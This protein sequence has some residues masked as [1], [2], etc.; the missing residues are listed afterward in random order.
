MTVTAVYHKANH[1]TS[2]HPPN[3]IEAITHCL[4][5]GAEWIEIDVFALADSDYLVL[6]NNDL[7]TETTGSGAV[8]ERRATQAGDLHLKDKPEYR[9]PLLSEV[10]KV[11]AERGTSTKLQL[12]FKSFLPFHDDEPLRRLVSLV[13]P[14]KERV[15]VSSPADWHLRGL[16]RIDT[17][18]T[19]GFDPQ[20]YL[21]RRDPDV[22]YD[23]R[24][25][26]Y[27]EGAYGYHDD[28]LLS[29]QR[30]M[31][32]V[33]YLRDRCEV[34]L[35]QVPGIT[36]FYLNY[37]V[38]LASL[39]DGFNW[40]DAIGEVDL[41]AWTLDVPAQREAVERLYDSGVR[42]FTTDTPAA[43]GALLV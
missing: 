34:L 22:E 31:P 17:A 39:D 30:S 43:L 42:H 14:I 3:T 29:L 21:A 5:E 35:H 19:L 27:R 23:P 11:F 25:P 7:S 8:G 16:H 20:F 24:L 38:L 6:H 37:R 13:E 28:S 1:D 9:V 18:L 26:P 15:L 10:V 40:V 4:D 12:D 36:A 32:T 2:P 33:D 41:F